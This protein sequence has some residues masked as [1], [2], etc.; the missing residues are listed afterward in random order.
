MRLNGKSILLIR[1]GSS[2]A[3]VASVVSKKKISA[4]NAAVVWYRKMIEYIALLAF[5][6]VLMI[7]ALFSV[8][9]VFTQVM[10]LLHD[11]LDEINDERVEGIG[12]EEKEKHDGSGQI[13]GGTEFSGS[14]G[15]DAEKEE[16]GKWQ[17]KKS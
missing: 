14:N 8:Y 11:L 6:A 5:Y 9:Y 15:S 3:V 17:T 4:R 13:T 1:P 10:D 7:I 2:A 12:E 16:G